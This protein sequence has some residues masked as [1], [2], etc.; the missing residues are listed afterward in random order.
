MDDRLLG[1]LRDLAADL[2]APDP[3]RSLLSETRQPRIVCSGRPSWS[4]SL[5][6]I[7]DK[8][9]VPSG[10]DLELID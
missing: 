9:P 8:N 6:S 5:R 2:A 7:A 1:L 3:E 10:G 4:N